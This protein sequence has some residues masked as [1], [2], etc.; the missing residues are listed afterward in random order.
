MMANPNVVA[1]ITKSLVDGR[2]VDTDASEQR[3]RLSDHGFRTGKNRHLHSWHWCIENGLIEFNQSLE[4]YELT[5][6]GKGYA[7]YF[8]ERGKYQEAQL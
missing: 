6:L 3:S 5:P 1:I 2:D 8:A 4:M 7:A